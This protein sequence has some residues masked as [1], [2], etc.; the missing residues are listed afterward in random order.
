[1]LLMRDH[2]KY[3]QHTW[4][5]NREDHRQT[6]IDALTHV[7]IQIQHIDS[8]ILNLRNHV[9]TIKSSISYDKNTVKTLEAGVK[10]LLWERIK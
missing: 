6:I 8:Y 5:A 7:N 2:A 9:R 3:I 1:M 10:Q 4:D